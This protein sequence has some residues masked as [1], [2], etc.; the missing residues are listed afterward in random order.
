MTAFE[1]GYAVVVGVAGYRTPGLP[2]LPLAVLNDAVDVAC[3]LWNPEICG[4]RADRVRLVLDEQATEQGIRQGLE[5]LSERCT[6]K[7]TGVFFFSGHG[8]QCGG[9]SYLAAYDA[10]I[11]S[12]PAG[13]IAGEEL[14]RYLEAIEA[15]RLAV[16]LD[17][18]FAGGIGDVKGGVG[19]DSSSAGCGNGLDERTYERLTAGRGRVLIASSA[20]EERSIVAGRERNSVFTSCLLRGLRGEAATG[21]TD[22]LGIFDLFQYVSRE[23]RQQSL[24]RQNPLFKARVMDNFSVSLC[25]SRRNLP[26]A[27]PDPSRALPGTAGRGRQVNAG[28]YVEGEVS[29]GGMITMIDQ[30]KDGT[31]SR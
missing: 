10:R 3:A 6:E 16:F 25:R 9:E 1:Q 12:S 30:R 11:G 23:V 18:C 29:E 5:W 15:G 20:P 8:W 4:Y 13:M 31:G 22:T 27:Q 26:S 17:S 14:A 19:G 24:G 21:D 28:I 7:D 2:P